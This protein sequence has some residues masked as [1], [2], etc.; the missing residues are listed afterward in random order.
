MTFVR[1]LACR[2]CGATLGRVAA[3]ACPACGDQLDPVYDWTA[4]VA[5]VD[6]DHV[7]ARPHTMWRYA[8]LL[9]L[10]G[11]P[12]VSREVGWSPLVEAPRL[13]ET[14]DVGRVWIKHDGALFPSLSFKD[15]VVGVAINKAL[16]LGMR[17]VACPSTG[18]LANAVAAHAAAAGLDAWIFVPESIERAKVIGTAVYGPR[19][20]RVRGTYDEINVLC[21]GAAAAFG[22]AVVNVNLRA[23]YGEGS[24]TVAYEIAEQLG[25]RAPGAVVAPMAGGSLVTK[26]AAGFAD[27]ERLQW[28]AGPTPRICGAQAAGC[29]PIATAVREET[30][31]I[32]PVR[33]DTLAHSLA[34]GDPVDG[35]WATRAIRGSGGWAAA[36]PDH[37][38]V[39]GM[40]L[41]A[42]QVGVFGETAGG[43]TVAA[44]RRLRLE[45]HLHAEDEVV[46]LSTGN[47]MKTVAALEGHLP[48]APVIEPT[49]HALRELV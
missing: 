1:G 22:W 18:N 13:A 25:W 3:T 20:V 5:T 10:D 33:P 41:L 45:G 23:Y 19:L 32:R 46:L 7:A 26:L 4:I 9:P 42:Q 8:E 43:V 28:I 12:T 47:G 40:R 44:A 11:T 21:R 31:T 15:R 38:I 34:I 39:A 35:R 30:E 29:A 37:E 24:K 2:A 17:T 14:L 49:L 36:A 48:P 27:L 6:R 16:E